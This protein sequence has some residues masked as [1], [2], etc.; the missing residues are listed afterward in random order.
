MRRVGALFIVAIL[1]AMAAPA[2]AEVTQAQ[3]NEARA[4]VNEMSAEL[5]EELAVLDS[6]LARQAG[7]E[8]R[9]ARLQGDIAD[10]E[11]EIALSALAAR[12]QARAMYVSAG[13]RK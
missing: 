10:R 12:E 3:L 6:V 5:E 8:L 4:K 1:L 13:D 7:Y 11:R 2:G 9:I